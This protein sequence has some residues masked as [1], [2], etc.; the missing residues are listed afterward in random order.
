M[1]AAEIFAQA[2]P[3]ISESILAFFHENDRASHKALMSMLATRRKLR[4]VFLEQKPK[5][6]RNRWMASALSR[7]A[8]E[9][10]AIEILQTWI[11]NAKR[12]LV[13]QFLQDLG[14]EHD[15]EG[16]IEKTPDEPPAALVDQAVEHLLANFCGP[17]VAIYLTMFVQMDP[18]GWPHLREI[19]ATRPELQLQTSA[20]QAA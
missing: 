8:N 12:D 2:P 15:G 7:K 6:E 11:L 4:P 13:L 18:S 9:D 10:L 14:I 20:T 16:V 1:N 17:E 5:V 19:L 3:E